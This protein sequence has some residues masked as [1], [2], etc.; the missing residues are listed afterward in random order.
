MPQPWKFLAALAL[1]I[2]A[3]AAAA[4]DASETAAL[5]R[6]A[7]VGER[8]F[9][10]DL[11][12]WQGSDDLVAKLPNAHQI[13]RGWIVDGPI[14]DAELVFYGQTAAGLRIVYSARFNREKLVSSHVYGDGDDAVLSP[15]RLAM[16]AARDAAALAI[17]QQHT[18]PCNSAVFN[19]VVLPPDAPGGPTHVYFLSP[20]SN[21]AS[22]PAGGHYLI[23]VSAAGQAG[24]QRAFTNSCIDLP[25]TEKDGTKPVALY[26]T[27]L[28][29]PLPTEIHVYAAL[30]A[31]LPLY[32]SAGGRTWDVDPDHG[33]VSISEAAKP[34]S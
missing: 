33:H 27:H 28:L 21:D 9:F 34:T 18:P 13:V 10:Y 25:V 30:L 12:A 26:I 32:V 5:D 1:A 29:D 14:D 3:P 23:D 20:Q 24:P 19:T 15:A 22:V 17:A 31:G 2:S 4:P 8:I 11:D 6:A 16:I 7:R